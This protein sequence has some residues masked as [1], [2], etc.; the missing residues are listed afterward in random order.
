MSIF[1]NRRR[2]HYF[3]T[4]LFFFSDIRQHVYKNGIGFPP[5]PGQIP[6][7][8]CCPFWLNWN[9]HKAHVHIDMK[10]LQ[11]VPDQTA[12][13]THIS[14]IICTKETPCPLPPSPQPLPPALT[15]PG[16]D[17]TLPGVAHTCTGESGG[18]AVPSGRRHC[19]GRLTTTPARH[20]IAFS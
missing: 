15:V 20:Q 5:T 4:D 2:K 9:P 11:N 18:R 6:P 12:I 10:P 14:R 16:I 17:P 7:I 19:D 13:C 3:D 1:L 8:S